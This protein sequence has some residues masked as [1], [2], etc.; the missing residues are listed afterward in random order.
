MAA[1]E[2]FCESFTA[3]ASKCE[4][5]NY[6]RKGV[7]YWNKTTKNNIMYLILCQTINETKPQLENATK[8]FDSGI[9]LSASKHVSA[10]KY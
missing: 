3:M 2:L 8:Y 10:M 9:T 5:P 1:I 6:N 7:Y 4:H